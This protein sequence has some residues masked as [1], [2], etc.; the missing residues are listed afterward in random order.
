[1]E[2]A[3][4][5]T[6]LEDSTLVRG[7]EFQVRR[8]PSMPSRSGSAISEAMMGEIG[9]EMGEIER[10]GREMGEIEERGPQRERG[11]KGERGQGGCDCEEWSQRWRFRERRR[12]KCGR[13]FR[14]C[15]EFFWIPY[16][17]RFLRIYYFF[18][19]E[20]EIKNI[21]NFFKVIV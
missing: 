12:K 16:F 14:L 17:L 7:Q 9:R 1:M 10:E 6:H 5:M 8:M 19:I 4:G 21:L 15:V 2:A 13:I 11:R 20:F 3:M 18:H